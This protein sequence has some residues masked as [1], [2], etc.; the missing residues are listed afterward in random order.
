MTVLTI[1]DIRVTHYDK[2]LLLI[3]TNYKITNI[4]KICIIVK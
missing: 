4:N 2:I 3:S 1:N